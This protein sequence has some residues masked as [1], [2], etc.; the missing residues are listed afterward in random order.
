MLTTLRAFLPR[1]FL[2]FYRIS[3]LSSDMNPNPALILL[4]KM[5][6]PLYTKRNHWMIGE[7]WVF[8]LLLGFSELSAILLSINSLKLQAEKKKDWKER[9]WFPEV[10]PGVWLGRR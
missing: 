5:R 9:P 8:F 10:T 2:L 7:V 3:A 6:L 1:E 4:H